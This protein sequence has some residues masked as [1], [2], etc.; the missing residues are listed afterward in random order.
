M[1]VLKNRKGTWCI[2]DLN[3]FCQEGYCSN[4]EIAKKAIS[5]G[6]KSGT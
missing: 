2:Y 5:P 3:K 4:C 1:Q 6:K